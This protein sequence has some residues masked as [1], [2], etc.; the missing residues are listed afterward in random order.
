MGDPLPDGVDRMQ[1]LDTPHIG[2]SIWTR[3]ALMSGLTLLIVLGLLNVFGQT[4]STSRAEAGGV[5]LQVVAP[6]ALRGGILYQV[7]IEVTAQ[8]P[9]ASADVVMSSG[10]FSGVTTNAEVPAPSPQ[11]SRSGEVVF[12]IGSLRAGQE[13]SLRIYFQVN[14]TTVAWRRPLDVTLEEGGRSV[15]A[16]HRSMDIYP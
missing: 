1:S 3:R 6:P 14:P 10:W 8:R 12:P 13:R 16:I 4:T 11:S 7:V 2:R 9:L 15:V 5:T